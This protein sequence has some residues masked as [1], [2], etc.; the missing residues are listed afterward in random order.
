[1]EKGLFAIAILLMMVHD[2]S[3]Q[4]KLSAEMQKVFD[5]CWALR[6]AISTGNATGLKCANED[7]KKCKVKDFSSLH[8]QD[9]DTISLNGHFVWDKEFVDSLIA[10]RDVRKFAQRYAEKL[11]QKGA[12]DSKGKR[13]F[14]KSCAVK[15]QGKARFTFSSSGHQELVVITEPKGKVSL[16]VHCK[17]NKKWYNDDEAV[18]DG[19][20]YR[21]QIFDVPEGIKETVELEVLNCGYDDISFVIISN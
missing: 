20:A 13:V 2:V 21:Q 10:G 3:A 18:N 5:V 15:K 6:T 1:M 12:F 8:P 19:R 11:A 17:K 9:S 7:F 16:R 4:S 14:I